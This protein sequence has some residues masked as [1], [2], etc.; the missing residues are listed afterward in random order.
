MVELDHGCDHMTYDVYP[1][2][3]LNLLMFNDVVIAELGSAMSV[4]SDGRPVPVRNGMKTDSY[5]FSTMP[6]NLIKIVLISHSM[7]EEEHLQC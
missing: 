7:P 1:T 5:D 3:C 2:A 4:V 6:P